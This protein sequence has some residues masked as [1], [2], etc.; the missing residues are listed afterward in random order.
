M[1]NQMHAGARQCVGLQTLRPLQAE[2]I[3]RP[4]TP[5]HAINDR[6]GQ[7]DIEGVS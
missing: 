3:V 1:A 7:I 4:V 6:F 2:D 5:D